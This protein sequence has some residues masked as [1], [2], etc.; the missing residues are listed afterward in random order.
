MRR[1]DPFRLADALTR[2]TDEVQPQ[3]TLAQV[4]RSWAAAVGETIAGW[5]TPASE[6]AGVVTV[7]C[8]DS[9]VAHELEMIKPQLLAQLSAEL[10]NSLGSGAISDLK[11][12]TK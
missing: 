10:E 12:H 2:F 1:R 3:S 9:V 5:A 4:Q 6:R 7:T 8:S 11:F